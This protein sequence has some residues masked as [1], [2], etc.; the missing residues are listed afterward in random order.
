MSKKNIKLILNFNHKHLGQAGTIITV[1]QGYARNY[2][3][4][5]NIAEQPTRKRL[6]YLAQL[7]NKET[8]LQKQKQTQA[9]NI[10]AQLETIYK[11]SIKRKVS[12][13]NTIFGSITDK[14]VADTINLATGIN[15]EKNQIELPL[16][17]NTGLYDLNINLVSTVNAKIRLQVLP[18][19]I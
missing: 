13:N 7:K 2:L 1:S 18:E 10:K 6:H 8:I 12:D 11:F 14:D 4:P 16:I 5:N 19:T 9:T 17:K 3:I 15:L